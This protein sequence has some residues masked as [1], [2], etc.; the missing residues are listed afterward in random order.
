MIGLLRAAI[1]I[2][3]AVQARLLQSVITV[4]GAILVWLV[5]RTVV[6]RVMRR[7]ELRYTQSRDIK[8]RARS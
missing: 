6:R 3:S 2:D 1:E 5:T 4:A 7:L 8:D